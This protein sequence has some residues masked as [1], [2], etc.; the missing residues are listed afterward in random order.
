VEEAETEKVDAS[1]NGAQISSAIDIVAKV[2][3]G[4]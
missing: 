1:Y 2:Q 4:V 3:E